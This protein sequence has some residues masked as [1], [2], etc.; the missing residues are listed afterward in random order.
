M[1]VRVEPEWSVVTIG[2]VSVRMPRTV[3][4]YRFESRNDSGTHGA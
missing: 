3:A 4:V 2:V 1:N